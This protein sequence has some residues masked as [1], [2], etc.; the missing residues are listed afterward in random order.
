[1]P[2]AK[3]IITEGAYKDHLAFVNPD[4]SVVV[5]VANPTDAAKAVSIKVNGKT[6]APSLK[7]HS[8]NTLVFH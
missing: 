2:G 3:K 6:Y 1:M 7:A 5:I 8:F 4:G